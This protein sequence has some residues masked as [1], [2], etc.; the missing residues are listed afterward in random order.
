MNYAIL[1]IISF[2]IIA[3]LSYKTWG[4][5]FT[6]PVIDNDYFE[7]NNLETNVSSSRQADAGAG[8]A[9]GASTASGDVN[10][11]DFVII[12][13]DEEEEEEDDDDD[14]EPDTNSSK[15]KTKDWDKEEEE[16]EDMILDNKLP[17]IKNKNELMIINH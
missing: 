8:T 1:V 2:A 16:E 7:L 5:S 13:N 17:P 6:G 14:D 15:S 11:D 10:D 4:K 12:G 9:S 3:S